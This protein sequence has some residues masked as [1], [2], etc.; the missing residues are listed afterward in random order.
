MPV[1]AS[2]F[3]SWK[4][5]TAAKVSLPKSPSAPYFGRTSPAFNNAS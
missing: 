5:L 2:P 4:F 3:F 1:T